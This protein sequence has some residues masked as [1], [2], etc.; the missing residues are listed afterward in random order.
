MRW[1]VEEK[2]LSDFIFASDRD[3]AGQ[4]VITVSS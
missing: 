1:R 4:F 3:S 2:S